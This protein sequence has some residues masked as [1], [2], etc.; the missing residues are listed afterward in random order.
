M[1]NSAGVALQG[2]AGKVVLSG[3]LLLFVWW[4][5]L[6]LPIRASSDALQLWAASY[7]VIAFY[8]AV[9]GF[10]ISARWG[11]FKSVMGRGIIAFSLGLLLQ[12]FGQSSYSYYI[13]YLNQP[14]PYPSAGDIGFFGSIPCYLYGAWMLVRAAGVRYSLRAYH[15]KM[16]AILLPAAL[17]AFSY[18]IFLKDYTFDSTQPLKTFLD[19]GYPLGQAI[20]VSVAILAFILS[21]EI[22]GGVMRGPILTFIFALFIE[23]VSDFIFLYEA[24]HGLWYAGGS[25]DLMYATAYLLMAIALIYTG[26]VFRHIQSMR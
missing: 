25:N 13:Y 23:Y 18:T 2:T 6:H 12:C 5:T 10:F 9:L 22:L 16:L 15:N 1:M 21:R 20:Y 19:F 17:L 11:G 4:L 7:Q 8:G 3:Y 14:V 26:N 24:N